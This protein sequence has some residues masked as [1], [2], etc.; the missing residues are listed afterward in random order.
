MSSSFDS[1]LRRLASPGILSG[2]TCGLVVGLGLGLIFVIVT[3]TLTPLM[4]IPLC[5]TVGLFIGVV[6]ELAMKLLG[7]RISKKRLRLL[8]CIFYGLTIGA[9]S[10]LPFSQGLP[11]AVYVS[12]EGGII[13]GFL[14]ALV[15][16][17]VAFA[18]HRLKRR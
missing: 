2:T 6:A 4:L 5:S 18:T 8:T 1:F 14:G 11:M 10:F 17:P 3:G 15:G 7:R 16:L 12:I 13:G 9:V